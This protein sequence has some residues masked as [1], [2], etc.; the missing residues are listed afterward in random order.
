MG[1]VAIC[2]AWS[3]V[4]RAIRNTSTGAAFQPFMAWK[5]HQCWS[6]IFFLACEV[7]LLS[8][9]SRFYMRYC[10]LIPRSVALASDSR[11]VME[12]DDL[13][14]KPPNRGDVATCDVV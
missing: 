8:A 7:R 6:L 11:T 5:P 2:A 1:V 9:L 4:G 10:G 12:M 13:R 14:A 3:F